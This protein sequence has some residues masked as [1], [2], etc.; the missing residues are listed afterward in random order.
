MKV[1]NTSLILDQVTLNFMISMVTDCEL[2]HNNGNN[3]HSS[4]V[5]WAYLPV[6]GTVISALHSNLG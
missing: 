2:M 5:P 1:K 3:S 4:H 6:S